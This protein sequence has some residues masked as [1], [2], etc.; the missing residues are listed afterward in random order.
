VFRIVVCTM[1]HEHNEHKAKHK[2]CAIIV[3]CLSIIFVPN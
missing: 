2:S 3:L 1:N